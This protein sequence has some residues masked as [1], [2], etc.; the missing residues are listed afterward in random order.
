MHQRL[1]SRKISKCMPVP[2]WEMR[3]RRVLL[4]AQHQ[5]GSPSWSPGLVLWCFILVRLVGR[6][7]HQ[8]TRATW[9]TCKARRQY[10]Q[11]WCRRCR[12]TETTSVHKVS[13]PWQI[14]FSGIGWRPDKFSLP[15]Q[16]CASS[17]K[18]N[19]EWNHLGSSVREDR[20]A[21]EKVNKVSSPFSM[22][23][24]HFIKVK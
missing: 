17:I 23:I 18:R 13:S 14:R 15:F 20:D 22:K 9:P 10:F 21:Y 12:E 7:Q 16:T 8:A 5:L 2:T 3:W 24:T 19:Y 11:P 6:C 1:Y 4:V